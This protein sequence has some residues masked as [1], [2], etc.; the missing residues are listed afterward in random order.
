M[1]VKPVYLLAGVV[2]LGAAV[3]A[4]MAQRSAGGIVYGAAESLGGGIV[5]T[6]VDAVD[7]LVGGAVN[8]VGQVVGL[9]PTGCSK[10]RALMDE[11]AAAPW[12]EKAILSFK[13]S[14][15]CP[16]GDYLKWLGDSSFR[17]SCS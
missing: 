12:Y 3:Y 5:G 13:V 4:V 17:P 10:C 15:A 8:A 1:D 16:A 9:A 11:F 14:A 2:V 6:A 7:G